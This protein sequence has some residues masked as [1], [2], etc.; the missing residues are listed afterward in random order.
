MFI[1]IA[2]A[3]DRAW[4]PA[5]V[6]SLLRKSCPLYLVKIID[7]FL[8]ERLVTFK[9]GRKSYSRHA[10]LGCPQGGILSPFLWLVLIDD[11]L[12]I[13]VP[14]PPAVQ[15]HLIG[16][17]D[18]IVALVTH[19]CQQVASSYLQLTCNKIVSALNNVFLDINASKSVFIMFCRNAVQNPS[20]SITLKGVS[21]PPCDSTKY[22]GLVVDSGL[23]W[24]EHIAYKCITSKKIANR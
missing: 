7:N 9:H 3:F 12:K 16:Y 15:C 2:S 4:A 11:I 18:D 10:K 6:E 14:V 22:L 1:D 24:R 19:H 23:K 21:I 5:I 8:D 17:A 13:T 20:L